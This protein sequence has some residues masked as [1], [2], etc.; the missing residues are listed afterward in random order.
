MKIFFD[1]HVY[2]AEALLGETAE[3][4]LAATEQAS[5]RIHAICYLLDELDRVSWSASSE[6]TP[7]RY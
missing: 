2:I 3:E 5:W 4:L 6:A 1:T 7:L